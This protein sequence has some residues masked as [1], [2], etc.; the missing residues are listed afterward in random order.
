MENNALKEEL[1]YNIK[2][3]ED[4]VAGAKLCKPVEQCSVALLKRWLSCH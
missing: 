2:L 1:V 4:D 3:T